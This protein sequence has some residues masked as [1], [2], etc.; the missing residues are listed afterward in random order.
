MVTAILIDEIVYRPKGKVEMVYADI[1]SDTAFNKN[2][3]SRL[4][5]TLDKHNGKYDRQGNCGMYYDEN[6]G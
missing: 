4:I 1:I 6:T 2:Q 5:Q 3:V